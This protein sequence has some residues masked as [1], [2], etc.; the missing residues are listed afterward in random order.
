MN[1]EITLVF[2]IVALIIMFIVLMATRKGSDRYIRRAIEL[3]QQG[4]YLDALDFFTRDSLEQAANMVLRTPEASQILALRRLEK[5][6]P[7]RQIEKVFIQLARTNMNQN[8]PHIAASA[9]ELANKPFAAAKVFIDIGGLEYVPAAV[10]ILD[11]HPSLIHDRDQAI[12]NLARHAY[13]NKKFMEAA[14]LLRTIGAEEEANT[15]LIAAANEMRKLGLT[16]EAEQYFTSINQP[17]RA[18]QHYL[19]ELEENLSQGDIEKTRRSLTITKDIVEKLPSKEKQLLKEELDTYLQSI[20]KYDRLLKILDSARDLLRKNKS[21]QA[22]ALYDELLEILGSNVPT[23]ILA[24]AALANEERNPQYAAELYQKASSRA[25]SSRA[26]ESFKMRAKKLEIVIKGQ[27][28]KI[29][30]TTGDILET[31]VEEFCSVCR[32]KISD[33]STLVRCPDCGSPAHYSH[34]AEWL[35]IRGVCPICKKRVKIQRPKT[36][37]F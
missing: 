27:L 33:P 19:S 1:G 6:Y 13:F 22:I 32:M 23:P 35:K 30:R 25:R 31:E 21:N 14:E 16:T 29:E 37:T 26:A 34:I 9:F 10:Q 11:R 4:R 36:I 17:A 7:P 2:V 8:A 15:V 12:R 5:M 18:I 24:E 3:E 28:P 20:T